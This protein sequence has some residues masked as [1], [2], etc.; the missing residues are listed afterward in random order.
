MQQ[1]LSPTPKQKGLDEFA[2][3]E[4]LL[5]RLAA[6]ERT[7]SDK[8]FV[9]LSYAQ[10]L[11]GSIAIKPFSSCALSSELSLKLTHFLR[12][13]HD[14]LLVGINTIIADNPQLTVRR[15]NGDNPQAVILDTALRFPPDAALLKAASKPPIIVTSEAAS[16]QQIQTLSQR[17]AKVLR[18]PQ[19]ARGT[20][21]LGATLRLLQQQGLRSIMVEGGGTVINQFLQENLVDYCVITVTPKIIGGFKAVGELCLA[22]DREPLVIANCQYQVLGADMIVHGALGAH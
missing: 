15:C 16:E 3:I 13:R 17:G 6:N 20:I 9:T 14:A 7:A 12:S 2:F 22:P 5:D 18:A 8:P 1:L 21:E 4:P 11:D 10:S 19:N